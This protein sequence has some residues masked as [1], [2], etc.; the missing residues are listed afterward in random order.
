LPSMGTSDSLFRDIWHQ[1]KKF[2][3]ID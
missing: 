1:L 2:M 3:L